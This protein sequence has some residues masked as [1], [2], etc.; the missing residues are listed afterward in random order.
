MIK[1]LTVNPRFKKGDSIFFIIKMTAEEGG[2]DVL[3]QNAMVLS[4][5]TLDWGYGYH[6]IYKVL[7]ADGTKKYV[8]ERSV[9][10]NRSELNDAIQGFNSENLIANLN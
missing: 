3:T 2:Y 8:N 4:T 5:T 10:N 6:H 7:C 1:P 9:A